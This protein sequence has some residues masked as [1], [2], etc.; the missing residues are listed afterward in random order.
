MK[1]TDI[2]GIILDMDGVLWRGNELLP[3][4]HELFQWIDEHQL[5]YALATNNSS[6][7][8]LDYVAKLQKA[9]VDGILPERVVTSGTATAAYLQS[10][11]PAGTRVHVFG[12]SGLHQI[13]ENAG[14]DVYSDRQPEVVVVGIKFDMTYDQ[15]AQTCLYIRAGAEFIG[16]N[17]DTTFPT[18]QGLTPGVGTMIAAVRTA[19]DVEP[20]IIGKPGKHMFNTALS[21]TQT[22]PEHTLMV[23]DR[24]DTDILGGQQAG[25]KTALLLTGV[26]SADELSN[27][28]NNIWSDVAFDGL[29]ELLKSWA[30]DRWYREKQRDNR[31]ANQ[32]S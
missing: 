24:L 10:K 29:P 30:G 3:G 15:L 28:N 31:R 11:Y 16:T 19:T 2:K 20:T 18:P 13:M 12:M 23:G 21:I 5:S 4:M 22:A 32:E 27:P 14:F 1:F 9:G 25:M 6:R 26:T 7:T 17:P 8:P